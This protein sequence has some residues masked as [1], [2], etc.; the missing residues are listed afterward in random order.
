MAT[1][2]EAPYPFGQY[3]ERVNIHIVGENHL[4]SIQ[5]V[6]VVIVRYTG[7]SISSYCRLYSLSE[8]IS[9]YNPFTSALH[10]NLNPTLIPSNLSPKRECSSKWDITNMD[11]SLFLVILIFEVK[12]K[13]H[14]PLLD[15]IS[16]PPWL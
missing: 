8:R 1:A 4:H 2:L 12:M 7:K 14:R 11:K 15:L 10:I 9:C 13:K 3:V 6:V 5:H 16:D